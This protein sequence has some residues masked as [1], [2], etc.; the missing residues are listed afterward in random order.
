M[1][2]EDH[3][4]LF[5]Q[6]AFGGALLVALIG[7]LYVSR[8][9]NTL[10]KRREE[11]RIFERLK[12]L[13]EELDDYMVRSHRRLD[14]FRRVIDGFEHIIQG[15]RGVLDEEERETLHQAISKDK[16]EFLDQQE[17]KEAEIIHLDSGVD[18]T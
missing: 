8:R 16:Q 15:I 11:E 13:E 14:I 3:A 9:V 1:H 4:T 6:M 17:K 5:F 10:I 18:K 12:V 2:I 7:V